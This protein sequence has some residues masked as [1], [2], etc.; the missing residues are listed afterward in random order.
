METLGMMTMDEAKQALGYRFPYA[1]SYLMKKVRS[2]KT[3]RGHYFDSDAVMAARREFEQK[4]GGYLT[5]EEA[6]QVLGI[7]P[8]Q[9]RYRFELLNGIKFNK[10]MYV[11]SA[12]VDEMAR[13]VSSE[14]WG[15]DGRLRCQ[16]CSLLVFDSPSDL[17]KNK[18]ALVWAVHRNVG[19]LCPEC[20]EWERRHGA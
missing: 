16:R 6:G 7:S 18:T 5:L 8:S 13:S 10:R 19:G 20:D 4:L 3:R 2:V 12:A 17:P 15:A 1:S 9:V 11:E 14:G